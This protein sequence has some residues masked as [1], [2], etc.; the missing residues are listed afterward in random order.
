M[1]NMTPEFLRA[2]KSAP[3][4]SS[5]WWPVLFAVDHA[6]HLHRISLDPVDDEVRSMIDDPFARAGDS[7]KACHLRLGQQQRQ[8]IVDT[9]ADL[10]SRAGLSSAI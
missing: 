4:A 1:R 7:S 10:V 3:S 5:S 8:R 9:L 2:V 6:Q